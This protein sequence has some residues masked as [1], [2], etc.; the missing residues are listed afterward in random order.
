MKKYIGFILSLLLLSCNSKTEDNITEGS[1]IG[2]N[3]IEACGY[4][5]PAKNLP[6]LKELIQKAETDKT[7]N[8]FGWIW[9]EKTSK[10]K[11]IFITN[12]CLGSG[13]ILYWIFDCE[14]NH[15]SYPGV[16]NCT[17]CEY[18]G[19]K[20]FYLVNDSLPPLLNDLYFDV[21][22]YSPLNH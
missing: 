21:I 20:H 14:G 12:M 1:S 11:D 18:V 15:L 13:G 7:G 5:N 8:Y 4:T 9:L 6:W 2:D 19:H 10:G 22:I 3:S 17:A 16:E